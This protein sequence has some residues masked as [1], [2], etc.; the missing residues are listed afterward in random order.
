[1]DLKSHV[2]AFH[3][4]EAAHHVGMAKSFNKL[5]EG[6][7][8]TADALNTMN[9]AAA[10]CHRDMAECCKSLAAEHIASGERNLAAHNAADSIETQKV[11]AGGETVDLKGLI[12]GLQKLLAGRIEPMQ[13]SVV[14]LADNP[15]AGKPIVRDGQPEKP[16]ESSQLPDPILAQA[17]GL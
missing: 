1:M 5:R 3:E 7:S 8:A 10:Q 11:V 13:G 14:P 16:G 17:I 9:P 12:D 4:A 2:K 6:H 15:W